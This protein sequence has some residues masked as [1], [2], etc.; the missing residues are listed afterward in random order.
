MDDLIRKIIDF[1]DERN[2]RSSHDPK[3]LA[4]SISLEANE[5]LEL[6][7]WKSSRQAVEG[8][9]G[10]IKD[11]LADVLIYA[12]TLAHDLN[13]DVRTAIL[14]KIRKNALKYPIG[15]GEGSSGQ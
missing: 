4:I 3:D 12:L 15:K 11:E 13:I 7:Q 10:D 14:D 1:R 9:L 8:S 2:W 6:F 5:L